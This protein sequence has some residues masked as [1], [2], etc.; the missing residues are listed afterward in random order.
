MSIGV[1]RGL[2][3]STLKY[4]LVYKSINRTTTTARTLA[5]ELTYYAKRRGG[6]MLSTHGQTAIFY[7]YYYTTTTITTTTT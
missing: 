4:L 2:L 7:T 6:I 3:L 5:P 1:H